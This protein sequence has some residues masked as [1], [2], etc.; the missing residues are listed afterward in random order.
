M[1]KKSKRRGGTGG[2]VGKKGTTASG[3][4]SRG[5]AATARSSGSV[6]DQPAGVARGNNYDTPIDA[7]ALLESVKEQL[8]SLKGIISTNDD[9]D[10]CAICSGPLTLGRRYVVAQC[11]G[12][13]GCDACFDEGKV[14]Y[15]SDLLGLDRCTFCN[16]LKWKEAAILRKEAMSG[17]AWAQHF[18]GTSLDEIEKLEEAA[19]WYQRAASHGHPEAFLALAGMYGDGMG[20][21]LDLK[22]ARMYA[23]KARSLHPALGVLCNRILLRVAMNLYDDGLGKRGRRNPLRFGASRRR[24]S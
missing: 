5:G 12:K 6:R 21:P 22:L 7:L 15:A 11:C 3:G 1:G 2:G 18:Y 10:A 24:C 8:P 14:G 19:S 20:C 9:P 16:S 23:E 4:A 17:N 13:R